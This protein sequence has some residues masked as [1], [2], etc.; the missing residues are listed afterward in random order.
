MMRTT[1]RPLAKRFVLP[2]LFVT[3]A[4]AARAADD[5][6]LSFAFASQ[7]GS[8]IY[9]IEGRVVQIYRIPI[10]FTLKPLEED[11]L[12]GVSMTLPLTFGFYDYSA[13]DVL[14]GR[15]PSHVGTASLLPGVE[16]NVRAMNNWILSPHVDVGAAKDF[17]GDNLVWVYD[18]G[19]RSVVSFPVGTWD[20]RAGQELLWAGAAQTGSPLTDWYAE[21]KAGF[22][23][24]HELPWS[25]GRSR[26]DVGWFVTYE[27]FF[28]EDRSVA[29]AYSAPSATVGVDEQ[30][31]IGLSFGTRPA[32]AWKWLSM[33]KLGL[34][35]Q[36]GDGIQSVRFVIGEIF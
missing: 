23:F 17:S 34:S 1:M 9:N 10:R 3:A 8:G 7:A 33:P 12:W 4:A 35:Y 28:K 14:E 15:F 26:W 18:A 30:T 32:L 5:K 16:F 19:V 22:E 6:P 25:S 29:V 24:R 11:E 27:H 21:A 36:F 31:E 2:L 20:G 13:A